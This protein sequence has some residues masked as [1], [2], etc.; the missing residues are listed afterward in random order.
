MPRH[1][2]SLNKAVGVEHLRILNMISLHNEYF[3]KCTVVPGVIVFSVFGMQ[4]CSIYM[5]NDG[6]SFGCDGIF[7]SGKICRKGPAAEANLT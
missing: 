3:G 4:K 1:F 6:K 2:I 5:T 7:C